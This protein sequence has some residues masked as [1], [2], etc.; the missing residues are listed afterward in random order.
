[1]KSGESGS[2]KHHRQLHHHPASF[3]TFQGIC[4]TVCASHGPL[5][6]NNAR[7]AKSLE[8]QPTEPTCAAPLCNIRQYAPN[9]RRNPAA[10]NRHNTPNLPAGLRMAVAPQ[11]HQHS[12]IIPPASTPRTTVRIQAVS[13]RLPQTPMPRQQPNLLAMHKAAAQYACLMAHSHRH[14]S[15]SLD[16]SYSTLQRHVQSHASRT[17][18]QCCIARQSRAHNAQPAVVHASRRCRI[19]W[20]CHGCQPACMQLPYPTRQLHQV[21]TDHL[22]RTAAACGK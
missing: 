7:V 5:Q 15:C 11:P 3:P 4:G 17:P 8:L 10:D 13:R 14:S 19:G 6:E 21:A 9:I 22:S 18:L 2:T 12:T 1:M 16:T 20:H